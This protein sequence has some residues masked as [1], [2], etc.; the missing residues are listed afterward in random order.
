MLPGPTTKSS[1]SAIAESTRDN[2]V[3]IQSTES[4]LTF[5][6][7]GHASNSYSSIGLE[8]RFLKFLRLPETKAAVPSLMNA[9]APAV[10]VCK[11]FKLVSSGGQ[12]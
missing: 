4:L 12:S 3:C 2:V 8:G 1:I 10:A 9:G 11:I 5:L 6:Q 7:K